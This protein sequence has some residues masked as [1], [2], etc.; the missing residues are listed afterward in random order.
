LVEPNNSVVPKPDAPGAPPGRIGLTLSGGGLRATL[1]HLGVVRLLFETGLLP[2]VKFIGGVSGGAILAMHLGLQ[3][4]RYCANAAAF[5]SAA[6]EIVEFCQL[7][8]RNRILRRWLFGWATIV[9]RAFLH[10]SRVRLLVATY[11]RLFGEATLNDLLPTEAVK[12]PRVIVHS[13]SLSTGQPCSF[14]R[15]GFMWYETDENGFLRER[16]LS[17]LTPHLPVAL[18][19]AAS[20]AFPP[21]FPPVCI[22]A[23]LL[24]VGENEFPNAQYITDG[25]VYDNLGIE[26]PLWYFE[27]EKE[28]DA[29]MVCD[30]GGMFD[31][32]FGKYG[33]SLPRNLRATE[34]LMKRVGDLIY[35]RLA[36]RG[37]HEIVQLSIANTTDSLGERAL[38]PAVQ[39]RVGRIRTDLDAFT[40]IEIDSLIRHGYGVAR[41]ALA[42]RGWIGI[43]T[44]HCA[45]FP[46]GSTQR[47]A[48]AWADSLRKSSQRNVG[49]LFSLA[50]W[51]IW[52]AAVLALGAVLA[53]WLLSA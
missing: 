33:L 38:P 41:D 20:S 18:A 17:K 3:W 51:P 34:I 40:D 2:R 43:G 47:G 9:P 13:V 10:W 15:S 25:G 46:V 53:A 26:R 31:W 22:T 29:F 48:D 1:F 11:E 4:E 23:R 49:A 32:D 39:R 37:Q 12:R 7:D 27:Q 44:P 21:M 45:W 8:V 16:E 19:V 5:E 6:R 35:Q 14:G 42:A 36:D 30:A 50:D 52:A 24:H 28:L